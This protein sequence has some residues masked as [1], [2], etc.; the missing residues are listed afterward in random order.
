MARFLERSGSGLSPEGVHQFETVE[1]DLEPIRKSY[2][3]KALE[4]A[5]PYKASQND[6]QFLAE[7]CKR[8]IGYV[9]DMLQTI[10]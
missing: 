1:W 7:D 2:L 9:A 10:K 5:K 6:F 4:M 3:K 8:S